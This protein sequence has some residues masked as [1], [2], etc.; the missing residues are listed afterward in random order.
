[1]LKF[2]FGYTKFIKNYFII[3]LILIG[4]LTFLNSLKPIILSGSFN[5]IINELNLETTKTNENTESSKNLFDLNNLNSEIKNILTKKL[6]S[7]EDKI[8]FF[9]IAL[10]VINISI[11]FNG[12]SLEKIIVTARQLIFKKIRSD[13]L[14]K[15][16]S[17]DF[18]IFGNQKIGD[19]ISAIGN[20]S[21]AMSQGAVSFLIR[22]IS[23]VVLFIIFFIFLINTQI[24]LTFF[25]LIIL[26]FH[27][28][29]NLFLKKKQKKLTKA[30]LDTTASLFST[31][32]QFL[33]NFRIIKCFSAENYS[34]EVLNNELEITHDVER[35]YEKIIVREN[36]IR[37]LIDGIFEIIT[38]V[39]C[40]YFVYQQRISISGAIGYLYVLRLIVAPAKQI[41][42]APLWFERIK[43]SGENLK[44][45]K[46]I[47][48]EIISGAKKIET[49]K[50]NINFKNVCFYYESS[51]RK[52]LD[53]ISFNIKKNKITGIYGISGSGKSTITDLIL[54]LID[55]KEGR[56][57]IDGIDIKNFDLK[58][59]R[60]LFSIVPQ[61]NILIDASIKENILFGRNGITEDNFKDALIKSRCLEFIDDL[62]DGLNTKVGERGTK[63][64]GGQ[65]QR[66]C[67]AR[68]IISKPEIL[69]FDEATSN[70]DQENLNELLDT[71]IKLKLNHTIIIISHSNETIKICDDI[72]DLNTTI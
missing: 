20:D 71:I 26:S 34:N 9:I 28:F 59:Y 3:A 49:I 60:S 21:R 11:Y 54:R 67:I 6:I 48:I 19:M 44:K 35:K 57:L 13:Y 24:Y 38:I 7:F 37:K 46:D 33:T 55:P 40:L 5:I 41:A 47:E 17:L 12:Y 64:S 58:D 69:I 36:E 42:S 63:L 52:V 27:Y 16:I 29:L 10:L 2:I 70:L 43:S 45:I 68:A 39:L 8:I 31:I 56:I 4:T 66:I 53:N 15:V 23:S 65:K 61:E 32:N 18:L 51:K 14:K 72:I 25:L 50:N 30:N 1:M 62:K 22:T